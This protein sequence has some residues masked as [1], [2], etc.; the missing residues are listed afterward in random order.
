MNNT[1]PVPRYTY[2]DYVQWKEDW[3]LIGGY[4]YQLLPSAK[5]QH[6]NVQVNLSYQAKSE[7]KSNNCNCI[8][9]TELDWKIDKENVVRP[10]VMIVCGEMKSDYLEFPPVLIVEI[11]SGGS[12]RKDR[13]IK[14]ELYQQQGVRYYIMADDIKESVEVF[15]LIDNKY[16]SVDKSDFVLTDNCSLSFDFKE[17]FK[18]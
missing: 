5:W 17:I 10:D 11:L 1:I 13:N 3:E 8:V 12:I 14:F 7:I 2:E 16:K 6:N 15:E 4:P 18:K 9:F